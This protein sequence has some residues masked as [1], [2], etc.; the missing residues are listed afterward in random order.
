M[1]LKPELWNNKTVLITGHTG[2]KGSWLTALLTRL[3]AKV[4]GLSLEATGMNS[5]YK[6]GNVATMLSSEHIGDVRDFS[7]VSNVFED[8]QI[9]YVFHL[10]AQALVRDSVRNPLESITTNVVGTSN[11][12]LS[13]LQSKTVIGIT[14]VT[15]DKVY[16]NHEW[17]WPYR[18]S[19]QLGGSDPYSASKAASELIIHAIDVSN[20]PRN[21]PI[22]TAR[23]GN[24]IGGGDWGQERLVPDLVRAI[25][26]SKV[27]QIRNPLASRPW[28]HILDCLTGYLLLGQAHLERRKDVPKSLNFG[29]KISMNVLNLVDLFNSHLDVKCE[30]NISKSQL[31]EHGRLAL[32]SHLSE[33]YLG[34]L[35][36]YSIEE[37]VARTALWY[38]NF[39]SGIDS[40]TLIED[41]IDAYL[42]KSYEM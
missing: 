18:E 21:V 5:L 38:R 34:W 37:S 41:E 12:L 31:R 13:A 39:L 25:A 4:V 33:E 1:G 14:L 20:N 11:V 26:E 2:F 29:P 42:E 24:V 17:L 35:P 15:T 22:A 28:Q 40:K 23:A 9:D 6:D 10:A 3:G 32:D 30:V 7:F 16:K 8:H 19:D 36:L 27:L